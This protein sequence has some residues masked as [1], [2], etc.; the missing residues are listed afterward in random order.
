MNIHKQIWKVCG[1]WDWEGRPAWYPLY[2]LIIYIFFYIL[3]PLGMFVQ[4][5][6]TTNMYG[7]VEVLCIAFTCLCG[8]KLWLIMRKLPLILEL[9]EL[10]DKLDK[11]I[12][13]DEFEAI[14]M[15]GVRRAQFISAVGI[16]IN[17]TASCVLY[18]AR[19][20]GYKQKILIWAFYV[21]FDYHNHEFR[22]QALLFYQFLATVWVALTHA[23]MDAIGGSVYAVLE[24]HLEVLDLRMSRLGID[25]DDNEMVE[26]ANSTRKLLDNKK[27]LQ[28]KKIQNCIDIRKCVELHQ[29]C[30]R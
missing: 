9:F 19:V 1:C 15:N 7:K 25:D 21:P 10:M 13:S 16:I 24:A 20:F 2:A 17:G 18:A 28:L 14:I 3:F 30:I 23:T 4:F 29:L 5:F 22:Y 11:Q 12:V 26:A 6:Y 8:I 27:R